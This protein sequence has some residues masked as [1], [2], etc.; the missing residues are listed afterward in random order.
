MQILYVSMT[1]ETDYLCLSWESDRRTKSIFVIGLEGL[2]K[3]QT[4]DACKDS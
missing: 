4:P 3:L 1:W 2:R